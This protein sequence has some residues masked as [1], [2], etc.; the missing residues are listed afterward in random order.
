MNRTLPL[1][2]VGRLRARRVVLRRQAVAFGVCYALLAAA[3]VYL[4]DLTSFLHLSLVIAI[5]IGLLLVVTVRGWGDVSFAGWELH[6]DDDGIDLAGN[7]GDTRIGREEIRSVRESSSGL[8]VKGGSPPHR[9]WVPAGVEHYADVKRTL[10]E[11]LRDRRTPAARG[12]A[13]PV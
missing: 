10:Q 11:W 13:A 7:P 2:R 3:L 1:T 5:G 6:L 9:I 8:V 4:L 12:P